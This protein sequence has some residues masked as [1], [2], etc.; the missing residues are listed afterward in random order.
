[1]DCETFGLNPLKNPIATVYMSVYDDN[2]S[3][4]DDISLK[5]KPDSMD[6]LTVDHETEKIHGINWDKHINDPE[7]ITYSQAQKLLIDFFN[8]FKQPRVKRSLR[9][10]GQNVAFDIN[11]LKNT[12]FTP[13]L[14][15]KHIHHRYMDTLIILN[16]LQ[17]ID[18]VPA[19]L[20]N[21]ESLAEYFNVKKGDLH[22]AKED[23]KMTV[24]VYIRMKEIFTLSKRAIVSASPSTDLLKVIED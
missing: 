23:V 16:F 6:G 7:T 22:N 14:W 19:D 10:A 18:M 24:Q 13:E 8:K 17:D 2:D 15:E 9:P 12:I 3:F 20:G 4:M 21:L 5:V 1:M 11:Y